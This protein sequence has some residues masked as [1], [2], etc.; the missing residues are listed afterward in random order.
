MSA[1]TV[2][3]SKGHLVRLWLPVYTLCFALFLL[4]PILVVI[5]VSFTAGSAMVVP[6]EGFSLQWYR[7]VFDYEPFVSSL[8]TS[9]YV[10]GASVLCAIVIAVPAAL[11]LAR[12]KGRIAEVL[13]SFLLSPLAIP[14]LVI[15]L[16]LLFHLAKMGIGASF[17]ALLIANT[18]VSIPYILRTVLA[19]YRNVDARFGEAAAVLGATPWK[20]FW[21]VTLPL[22]SH[23]IFAGALFAMLVSLDNVGIA[24]FFGTAQATTLPVV[25]LAYAE[26]QFDPAIAA[27]STVQT[28]ITFGMLLLVEKF[29]GLRALTTE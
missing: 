8:I 16:S 17:F 4:A 18:V 20:T 11:G 13:V 10:A 5:A 1:P 29:F 12:Q 26:N 22:I 27:V 15:G 14:P 19:V 7:R 23:G 25:M 9:L 6:Y 2:S 28:L 21:H 3:S 24:Y